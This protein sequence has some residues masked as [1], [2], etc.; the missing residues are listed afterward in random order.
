MI[1]MS[2]IWQQKIDELKDNLQKEFNTTGNIDAKKVE[3]AIN[4]QNNLLIAKH[5][6]DGN[7]KVL[8]E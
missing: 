7:S 3:N 2:G 5:R 4:I 6:V 1:N 8:L